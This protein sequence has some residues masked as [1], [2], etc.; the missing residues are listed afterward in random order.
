M[1]KRKLLLV[2]GVEAVA[3]RAAAVFWVIPRGLG[4]P[5]RPLRK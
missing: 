5:A 1:T 2:T 3:H 4:Q